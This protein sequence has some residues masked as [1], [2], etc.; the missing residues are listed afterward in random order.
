MAS[1]A[2]AVQDAPPTVRAV[3]LDQPWLWLAAGWRDMWRV[4]QVSLL[5]GVAVVIASWAIA[6]L[7]FWLDALAIVLPLAAGFMLVGPLLAVGLYEASR[8]LE[9]GEPVRPLAVMF[10]A[11]RSPTQIAFMGV[12]LTG[13]LLVW[14]RIA[15]LLFALF[16]GSSGLPEIWTWLQQL[17]FTPTGLAFLVV[18]TGIGALLALA[19]FALSAISV[20][21]LMVRD[22]DVATAIATSVRAVRRNLPAMLLWGWLIALLMA[23]GIA[24]GFL[25]LAIMFPLV[26]HATW[27]AYRAIVSD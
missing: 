8:R 14:W 2:F 27:H 24:T 9:A 5:Y 7:L 16:Y 4:P 18:G 13:L 25:G 21:L 20:P 23:V 3:D 12:I 10:V 26:A 15:M 6:L 19:A 22:T 11:T 1:T 17:L